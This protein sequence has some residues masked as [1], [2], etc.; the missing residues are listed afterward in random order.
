[1][2]MIL[3]ACAAL[4]LAGPAMAQ[5]QRPGLPNPIATPGAL[6]PDVTQAN[7][8]QTICVRGWTATIRPPASY[9]T[10]LKRQQLASGPYATPG[11]N[12]RSYEEDHLISLELGGNPTDPHNLWPEPWDGQWGAHAKDRVENALKRAVC[13]GKIPLATAQMKIATDW[14][15][16]YREFMGER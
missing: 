8:N 1:M 10:S 3:A 15:A 13:A 7:I 12:L 6:N 11:A 5:Q 2:K 4:L 9:T 16:A 14:I